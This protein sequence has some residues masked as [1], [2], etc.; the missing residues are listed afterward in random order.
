L[1]QGGDD[2]LD[3]DFN[4]STG[5]TSSVTLTSGNNNNTVDCGMY[6]DA[7]DLEVTKSVDN[8]A[9]EVNDIVTF[10]IRI[11][12]LSSGTGTGIVL[13]D[14]LNGTSFEYQ[15]HATSQ[16]SYN[17]LTG[18]WTV[19]TIN[20]GSFAQMTIDAKVLITGVSS[21]T[22][23]ITAADQ[24]DPVPGNNSDIASVNATSSGGGGGGIES[25]G[26][27]SSYIALRKFIRTKENSTEFLNQ[28]SNLTTFTENLVSSGIIHSATN[29]KGAASSILSYVPE[30]GPIHSKGYISTPTD[31][32]GMSNATEVFSV[33]YFNASDKRLG[34]IMAMTTPSGSVYNHTKVICDRLTG[35]SLENV[36]MVDIHG[37]RFIL[38]LIAQ[39]NGEMD[40]TVSFVAY[41]KGNR[42]VIDNQWSKEW[43]NPEGSSPVFNFQVWSISKETTIEMVSEILNRMDADHDLSFL[44][45]GT[46]GIPTLFVKSG[47][48][49]NGQLTLRVSN[50]GKASE[51]TIKGTFTRTEKSDKEPLSQITLPLNN[52]LS[53][54]EVVV[55]VGHVFDMG[56][57]VTSNQDP[58]VDELYFAD[59]A[60][61][62]FVEENAGTISEFQIEPA[63]GETQEQEYA[64]ERN[65]SIKGS[66]KT[67][68]S[69]FR[70]LTTRK[71]PVDLS[72]FNGI[73]FEASGVGTVEILLVKDGIEN[74]SNQ[75]RKVIQLT[76]AS[77]SYSI[78]YEDFTSLMGGA[79][80]GED[81]VSVVFNVLGNQVTEVPFDL[82]IRN[83]K[84]EIVQ[85][86][87]DPLPGE[88]GIR[89]YPNPTRGMTT[90]EFTLYKEGPVKVVLYDLTGRMVDVV[91]E[92]DFAKGS[93][94]IMYDNPM[95][96]AGSYFCRLYFDETTETVQLSVIE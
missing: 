59:G 74:W 89:A 96:K 75:Y 50:P 81:V 71:E 16:G 63:N 88:F 85:G 2:A 70:N 8:P 7:I 55:P 76:P 13:N 5:K 33:D 82:N 66:V 23:S 94:R 26:D 34:V 39:E 21:N 14:L 42:F 80:T 83:L 20:G 25:N 41:E 72:S 9:P 47:S 32:L 58:G 19:G 17:Q 36:R 44:N 57:T 61:G 64:V 73:A 10:T 40:N 53:E 67:Y 43:Y 87:N 60:W 92:G 38:S 48:Y 28:V 31:L 11:D 37:H 18:V 84:F 68:V 6:S 91:A 51:M 86:S 90:L 27:L 30:S 46:Q 78:G 24:S 69:L 95:L 45:N 4:P 65:A 93:H 15:S 3:S 62:R 56:F 77:I 35:G 54:Q 49:A 22:A 12:N 1:D 52:Q 29:L 79:F